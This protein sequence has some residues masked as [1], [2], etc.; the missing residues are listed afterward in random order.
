MTV[1]AVA[2]TLQA[3]SDVYM[4]VVHALRAHW[5]AHDNAYPQKIVLTPAQA[6]RL[7]ELQ[8]VG[9][10]PFP[11]ARTTPRRDRFMGATV[12]VDAN[13]SGVLIAVDGTEMPAFEHFKAGQVQLEKQIAHRVMQGPTGLAIG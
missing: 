11:D 2:H 9:M 5:Q 1:I 13:T 3:M 4:N 10:V 12:E 7:L 6:D 8:Q